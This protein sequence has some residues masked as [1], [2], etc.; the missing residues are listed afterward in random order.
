[1]HYDYNPK[2]GVNVESEH[3]TALEKAPEERSFGFGRSLNFSLT[4]DIP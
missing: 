1:M 3:V 4:G 2:T